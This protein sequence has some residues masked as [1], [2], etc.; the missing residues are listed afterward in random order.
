MSEIATTQETTLER[1]AKMRER[2]KQLKQKR[3]DERKALVEQK[4]EQ[5]WR[6]QCEEMRSILVKRNQDDVCL[7]RAEQLRLKA[8]Q[9]ERQKQGLYL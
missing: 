1:Q 4:L 5:R 2:A 9:R 8:E 6:D 7:E 3:E